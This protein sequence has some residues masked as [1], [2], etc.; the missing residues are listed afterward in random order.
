MKVLTSLAGIVLACVLLAGCNQ[1]SGTSSGAGSGGPKALNLAFVTNNSANF[2]TIARR[3]TEQ[4]V[5]DVPNITVQFEI[6]SAGTAA[7]QKT[8]IDDLLAKGVDGIAISL[9]DPANQVQMINDTA[10][11]ALVFT[12]DSD[13]PNSDRTCYI[14]TDNKAAGR[15]AG[16]ELKKALPNGGKVMVFVGKKD[17]Q[18]AQDRFEGIKE[19]IAGT[20][21]QILDIRTDNTDPVRA[22]ANAAD[23][24]V[25][26]P[27]IA[28]MVG[29]WSYNGPAILNA[30]KDAGKAGQV[31]IVCFDEE[32]ETLAGVK[33]GF[34]Q[35]T[36][37]QQP[38]EFGRL[39][40]TNMAKYLR[41]D[42]SVV[43]E[44]K[45][46]VVPTLVIDKTNVDDFSAK[47]NKMLSK[48]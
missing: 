48:S 35:A 15:Q 1:Q 10:K 21:I 45:K 42:K 25:T 11:Q 12:Q 20:K 46:I 26:V 31:K 3:G 4:A 18:N 16:E 13:A 28:A 39:A 27:D 43:P 36:V 6:P 5:K 37:V 2:W 19:A 41:G 23:T 33:A 24:L 17:A 29:L 32:Q 44:D 7:E 9:I 8:I 30:V 40:I 47:L 14:G 34:I 22:K 38:Y